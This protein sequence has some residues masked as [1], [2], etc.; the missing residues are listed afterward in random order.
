[1]A[2]VYVLLVVR[3]DDALGPFLGSWGLAVKSL[4]SLVHP[5]DYVVVVVLPLNA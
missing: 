2:L 5:V 4:V 3:S 1:M